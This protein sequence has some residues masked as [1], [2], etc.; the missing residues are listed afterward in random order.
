MLLSVGRY[1]R[2]TMDLYHQLDAC[3]T[4][5]TIQIDSMEANLG[6]TELLLALLNVFASRQLNI[7]TSVF[8]LT[9]GQVRTHN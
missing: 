8:V 7:P 3:H 2:F 6:G 9:D 1:E 5:Q 4:L